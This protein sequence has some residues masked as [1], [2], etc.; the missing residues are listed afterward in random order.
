MMTR[1]GFCVYGKLLVSMRY[2]CV[3]FIS[4]FRVTLLCTSRRVVLCTYRTPNLQI[5]Q[6][7]VHYG[8]CVNLRVLRDPV[9]ESDALPL[10]SENWETIRSSVTLPQYERFV[11]RRASAS[12]RSCIDVI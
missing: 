6:S 11:N 1:Q 4:M 5:S 3:Y 8:R 9:L 10:C 7:G 2:F 12:V